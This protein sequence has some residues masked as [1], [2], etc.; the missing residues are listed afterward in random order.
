MHSSETENLH[1]FIPEG[2]VV[3]RGE[4]RVFQLVVRYK[5]IIKYKYKLSY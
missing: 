5:A 1:S 2:S 3:D 4:E